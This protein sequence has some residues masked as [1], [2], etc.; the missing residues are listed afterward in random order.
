MPDDE[1]QQIFN[2]IDALLRDYNAKKTLQRLQAIEEMSADIKE[3]LF[4]VID[5]VIL[6]YKT[7]EA[8]K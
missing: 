5:S 1:Q 8:Y 7:R 3:H 2:V 4:S 6:D